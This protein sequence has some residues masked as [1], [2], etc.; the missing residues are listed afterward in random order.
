MNFFAEKNKNNL[1]RDT[2]IVLLKIEDDREKIAGQINY[3]NR[4]T[5]VTG[6]DAIF[7]N[8]KDSSG[9]AKLI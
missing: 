7:K 4:C 1:V 9:H 2:N 3:A 6:I 5:A 8:K